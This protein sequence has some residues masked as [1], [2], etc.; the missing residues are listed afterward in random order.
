MRTELTKMSAVLILSCVTLGGCSPLRRLVFDQ[1]DL[2]KNVRL[3]QW[4][5]GSC[6]VP[7]MISNP[8]L[9]SDRKFISQLGEGEPIETGLVSEIFLVAYWVGEPDGSPDEI[10][11]TAIRFKEAA[12]AA[13]AAK[14]MQPEID[15]HAKVEPH[16]APTLIHRGSV[17]CI[18]SPTSAVNRDVWDAMVQLV[19]KALEKMP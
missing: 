8:Y 10:C 11:L 6:K 13:R 7:Q 19:E 5:G 4:K 3:A 18:M 2:P 16:T 15:K 14:A 12:P 9:S 17:V 1:K